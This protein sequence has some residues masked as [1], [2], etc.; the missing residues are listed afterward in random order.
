MKIN[1]SILTRINRFLMIPFL[2]LLLTGIVEKD[3]FSLVA[4][5]AFFIGIYQ[6]FSFLMTLF[7]LKFIDMKYCKLI[8]GYFS[9][10]TIYFISLHV[11]YHFYKNSTNE[12]LIW[13]PMCVVPVLLSF[14]WTYILEILKKET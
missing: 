10:V 5:L 8:L 9:M 14:F 1:I 11:I 4:V 7:Y 6:V 3:Y 13:I 2:I 12:E